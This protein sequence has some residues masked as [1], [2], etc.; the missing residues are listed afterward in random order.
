MSSGIEQQPVKFLLQSEKRKRARRQ[1]SFPRQLTAASRKL[2]K[3]LGLTGLQLTDSHSDCLLP[4]PPLI[5]IAE[6]ELVRPCGEGETSAKRRVQVTQ[7]NFCGRL[8]FADHDDHAWTGFS[9]LHE[10]LS[11]GAESR[12]SAHCS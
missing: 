8:A 11:K 9:K 4:I 1:N 10:L 2:A 7:G 6:G 12:T 3:S 5:Q